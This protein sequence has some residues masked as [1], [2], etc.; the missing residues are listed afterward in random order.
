MITEEIRN[1]LLHATSKALATNGPHGLN[2]VPVSTIFI[3]D[4]KILL[5]DYFFSKTRENL[6]NSADLA[7]V[8]WSGP[9]GWQIKANHE[10]QTHGENFKEIT[11]WAA[12]EFP[13]RTVYGVIELTPTHAFDISL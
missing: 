9:T 1:V 12:K 7:L 4:Q 5:V 11:T 8:G 13:E 2:V 10:Y 3:K 6:K